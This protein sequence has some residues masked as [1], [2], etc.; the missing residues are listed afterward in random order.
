MC[1]EAQVTVSN[2]HEGC[3][4]MSLTEESKGTKNQ[5]TH[6]TT[7]NTHKTTTETKQ[8]RLMS[9]LVLKS[10]RC[11]SEDQHRSETGR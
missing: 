11:R 4:E 9:A 3:E 1:R 10:K 8:I 2:S 6:K 7:Q 5:N